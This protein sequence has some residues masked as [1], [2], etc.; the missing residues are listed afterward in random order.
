MTVGDGVK[1]VEMARAAG[2]EYCKQK[3]LI[4]LKQLLIKR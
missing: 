3:R 2:D 4:Q 1:D